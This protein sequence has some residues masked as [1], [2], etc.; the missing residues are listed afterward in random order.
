MVTK[1][2]RFGDRKDALLVRDADPM[3]AF[4][5]Y[6]LPNRTDNEAFISEEIDITNINKFLEKKNQDSPE[7]KYTIFHVIAAAI[8]KTITLRPYMNRFVAGHRLYERKDIILSF[9]AKKVF[10]DEGGEVLIFLNCKDGWNIDTIN[11]EICK[12]V[13]KFRGEKSE[14]DYTTNVLG[15]LTK[16]PRFFLKMIVGILKFLDY[17]GKVPDSI[18]KEDPYYASVFISNLGSIKLNA[19]YH[20]LT[21]WGTNSIFVVIGQKHNA[22]VFDDEGNI[23]VR[24]VI[25]LG[26]TLDE[27]IAD[28]YY[29][30]KSIKLLKHLLENPEL[31]EKEF[32]EDVSYE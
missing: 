28:G 16:F 9:V 31:L 15:I 30:S 10:S 13:S 3:H 12:K 23:T 27:R 24:E 17:N 26:L 8:A 14:D 22:P 7:Y 25:N 5:P 1:K 29:Y 2:R 6:L 19:G 21:N 32:K 11:S 4:T 18:G 20:H